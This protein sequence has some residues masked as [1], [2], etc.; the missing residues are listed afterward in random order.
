MIRENEESVH[1]VM[2]CVRFLIGRSVKLLFSKLKSLPC[3]RRH[4]QL[5]FSRLIN[6]KKWMFVATVILKCLKPSLKQNQ[7]NINFFPLTILLFI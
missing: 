3:L 4:A 2:R 5:I 7:N 1:T 6:S